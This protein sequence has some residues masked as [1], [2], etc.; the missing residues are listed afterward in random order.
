MAVI[1]TNWMNGVN[2]DPK[3]DRLLIAGLTTTPGVDSHRSM[4]VSQKP[5]PEMK[6]NISG[7]SAF[8]DV[9]SEAHQGQYHVY[10]DGTDEV[11]FDASHPTMNRLDLVSLIVEDPQFTKVQP[12]RIRFIVTKGVPAASPVLP[13][14]PPDSLDLASVIVRKSV[15]KIQGGDIQNISPRATALGGIGYARDYLEL[16]EKLPR[17]DGLHVYRKDINRMMVCDGTSWNYIDT[18][19]SID[20]GWMNIPVNSKYQAQKTQYRRYGDQIFTKGAIFKYQESKSNTG[21]YNVM[22]SINPK[23]A[24]PSRVQ[25]MSGINSPYKLGV[26]F[27]EDATLRLVYENPTTAWAFIGTNWLLT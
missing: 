15:T 5:T 21:K 8:V 12:P 4:Y 3:D 23:Y 9:T 24:P 2:Y 22:A 27:Q 10:S 17:I 16:T 18:S 26:E 1:V 11:S 19:P 14:S 13:T 20:T 25:K 7:G 6:A